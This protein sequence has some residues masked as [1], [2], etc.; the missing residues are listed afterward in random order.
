LKHFPKRKL[1]DLLHGNLAFGSWNAGSHLDQVLM[2]SSHVNGRTPV[3]IAAGDAQ[4]LEGT[5]S[6]LL[7]CLR[8]AL[9]T[10]MQGE[11]WWRGITH[12]LPKFAVTCAG[13]RPSQVVKHTMIIVAC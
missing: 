12:R 8:Q 9:R 5:P 1:L 3:L 10:Q 6:Q 13:V 2:H 11:C 4:L 7:A